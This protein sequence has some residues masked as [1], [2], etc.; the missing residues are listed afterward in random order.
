MGRRLTTLSA[1]A[2][3]GL[4]LAGPGRAAT[5]KVT[6]TS[7]SG[8]GSLRAAIKAANATSAADTIEFT[9]PGTGPQR[10]SVTSP[11]PPIAHP[12]KIDGTSQPGYGGQPLV[13]LANGGG[14]GAIGIDVT[15]GSSKVLG[16]SI[17]HFLVGVRLEKGDKNVVAGD[18]LG[19]EPTGAPAGNGTGLEIRDGSASNT[20]GGTVP[21]LENLVSD[22]GVGISVAGSGSSQNVV[23]GNCVGLGVGCTNAIPNAGDGIR[24]SGGASGNRIGGTAAGS[25]NVL[26]GN[27]GEGLELRDPG[28]AN[29]LVVGNY[30]GPDGG[31]GH[32]FPNGGAG[33]RIDGGAAANRIGGTTAAEMNVI[34]EDAS[35]AAFVIDGSNGNLVRGNSIIGGMPGLMLS[36]AASGNTIGGTA[37]GAGNDIRLGGAGLEITGAGT[38]KNVISGNTMF[39]DGTGVLIDGGAAQNAIGATPCSSPNNIIANTLDGIRL[40]GAGTSG[41][42]VVCNRIGVD[43]SGTPSSNGAAGV[44]IAAGAT[45]NTI[46]GTAS[47]AANLI[48][49]NMTDGVAISGAGTNGN[50]V[51]GNE[52]VGN[53]VNGVSLS[54]AA[55][56]DR[57]GGTVAG[58]RNTIA[59][60]GAG[61]VLLTGSATTANAIEGNWIG[62]GGSGGTAFG[63]FEGVEL[64]GGAHGNTIGGTTAGARNVIS[65]NNDGGVTIGGA[66]TSGNLVEGNYIG[67]D[68]SGTAPVANDG[69]VVITGGAAG[70]TIGGTSAAAR[71]VISGNGDG[72]SVANAGSTGNELLGNYVGTDATGSAA[73]ENVVVGIATS[74]NKTTIGGNV[75]S[76]NGGNGIVLGGARESVVEGNLVGTA[77]DGIAPLP[78]GGEGIRLREGAKENTIGGKTSAAR[79]VVSANHGDG[80]CLDGA[81]AKNVVDGNLVGLDA[82]GG[83]LGNDLDGICLVNG[84]NG[85]TI[86]GTSASARNVVS[87][88]GSAG[89]ALTDVASTIVE[90]NYVGTNPAAS[91]ALGNVGSG[92]IVGGASD[93]N[94]IGG[95]AAG[96]RNV[97][98]GNGS[99]GVFIDGPATDDNAVEGNYI[100]TDAT[101][102][103]D[104]G[105]QFA[106]V[107][108]QQG[109]GNVIGGAVAGAG[110][111]ISGNGDSGVD[112][113]DDG[114]VVEGNLIGTNASGTGRIRNDLYGVRVDG[115]NTNRIGGTTRAERNV[116]SGN[117]ADGIA[118]E[119]PETDA[120]LIEGNYVGLDAAGSSKLP[121]DAS[122]ITV[123]G[124]AANTLVGGTEA[125]AGNVIS[126][127]T[128]GVL[129]ID[130]STT[131]TRIEGNLIGTDA[132]GTLDRGNV[133]EGVSFVVGA[134]GNTV[135]GTDPA[136]ANRIAFN[137][138]A[139]VAVDG[140]LGAIDEDAI[141]GNSIFSNDRLGID[142]VGNAND[143]LPAPTVDSVTTAGG[144][145]KIR[146]SLG[147]SVAVY[148]IEAFVSPGCDPSGAGEGETFLGAKTIDAIGTSTVT[149]TV[150]ALP[151][152]Q[153]VTA[154]ETDLNN[155]DTSEFS[156]CATTP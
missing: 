69:G 82:S 59:L 72:I 120:T 143:A 136:A 150:D 106:G 48:D 18:W 124:G 140:T 155:G 122:G 117:S 17:T 81:G 7:N 97:I 40:E 33:V 102:K 151:T 27:G 99:D 147:A 127:N 75:V 119:G 22:N 14:T 21:S 35:D 6:N 2:V 98:S 118:I 132:S 86:G 129:V 28:T 148:R 100:G 1:L 68:A 51:A 8:P 90:G 41:N 80:I 85:N 156:T 87:A 89:I 65:G 26:S 46:G 149:F 74:G 91:K 56:H 135:G 29:N 107:L 84:S 60:N 70:N 3:A 77:A 139:G 130:S 66:G 50:V 43:D 76:G 95:T 45:G 134:S 111:V 113:E 31:H 38:K 54:G 12:L 144:K 152:G 16:L 133:F 96:A 37:G 146:V 93:G 13:Q 42:A 114:N 79:N 10:I 78:N 58:A 62:V 11:L 36:G 53:A 105:N 116:I 138:G 55:A 125:G 121:N 49:F 57:V 83:K 131:G 61:G 32:V 39:R 94:T 126:A 88:N 67:T 123:H 115:G 47:G 73:L 71:N 101:G 104:V 108:V 15:A 25:R 64:A 20:I 52:V 154:T 128:I 5:F 145:T 110:N 19:L 141:E 153:K 92:V 9:L 30:V 63:N 34:E 112:L 44:A 137:G 109:G 142:L 24:I 23:V 4:A 103:N